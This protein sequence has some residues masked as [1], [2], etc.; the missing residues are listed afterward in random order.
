MKAG[1]TKESQEQ[2]TLFPVRAFNQTGD[3]M[4]FRVCL[5]KK[6]TSKLKKIVQVCLGLVKKNTV[7]I[8]F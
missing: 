7:W 4:K 8:F 1:L 5:K 2:K 3:V 6:C